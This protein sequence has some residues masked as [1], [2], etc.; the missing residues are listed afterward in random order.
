MAKLPFFPFYPNDWIIDTRKLSPMARGVWIDILAIA[1]NEPERGV[2]ERSHEMAA[3]ELTLKYCGVEPQHISEEC[4]DDDRGLPI[5]QYHHIWDEIAH[6]ATVTLSHEKVTVK[7]RRMMR[8]D[9]ARKHNAIRQ[10]RHRSNA[11]SNAAVTVQT[12]EVRSQKSDNYKDNTP[13]Y[14]PKGGFDLIWNRYPNRT[15]KKAA[16]R[17]YA[18]SVK[19]MNDFDQ[20][21]AALH[22]YLQS[23]RVRNGY[24]Q[25]GSTWFNNWR[26]WV[27]FVDPNRAVKEILRAQA[28]KPAPKPIEK[29]MSDEDR[30]EAVAV[31]GEAKRKLKVKP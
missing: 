30:A 23:E 13:L 31:F 19:T 20:L 18:A 27:Q 11:Q 21:Q 9:T 15:G 5:C 17:H 25:N 26:D 28:P 12:S 24:I 2:Y 29:E 10:S 14:P 1:W 8:F 22:N 6:V 4:F 7:S 3:N 16:E